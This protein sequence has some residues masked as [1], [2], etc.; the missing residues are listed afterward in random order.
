[1]F[2]TRVSWTTTTIMHGGRAA[3]SDRSR[4]L[5]RA[6]MFFHTRSRSCTRRNGRTA[7]QSRSGEP[8]LVRLVV[9]TRVAPTARFDSDRARLALATGSLLLGGH[10]ASNARQRQH[11]RGGSH[12][13]SS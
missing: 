6:S 2:A 9:N 13:Q 3:A 4:S 11:K 5:D 7:R 8:T 1:M 12:A 10:L